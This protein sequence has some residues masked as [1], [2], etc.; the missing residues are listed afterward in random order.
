MNALDEEVVR[1]KNKLDAWVRELMQ[2]H[3]S[4]E[5]GCSFW[6]EQASKLNFDPK[7]DIKGFDDL[8]LFGFFEEMHLRKGP[9]EKWIVKGSK[10]RN[11]LF[12][13]ET[14]GT[15]GGSKVRASFDDLYQDYED[16]SK[17][18]TDNEFPRNSHWLLLGPSGPRRL[19]LSIEYL[20]QIRG[21]TCFSI[22]M[23]P[24]W[25]R[26]LIQGGHVQMINE[27]VDHCVDQA[28]GTLKS[29]QGIRCLFA[30]PRLL[31]ALCEK[32]SLRDLGIKGVMCGGT[33]MTPQFHRFVKEELLGPDV[34]FVPTY[35]NTLMGLAYSKPFE[36]DK[37]DYDIIYYPNQVRAVVEIIKNSESDEKVAY[38]ESGRVLLSTLT[39][40]FF[41]PKFLERDKGYREPPCKL[42][43]WDGVRN[44]SP[45]FEEHVG[46]QG[47][48]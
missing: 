41:M 38:G 5:T 24:R 43:P 16:F 44:V 15:T 39:K 23:D 33:Q 27:Y 8:S 12:V 40:E 21:G 31:E 2:W 35:G 14:G 4:P 3:F 10:K 19:R 32:V 48:Y 6:L 9:I 28:L 13:F 11:H 45:F 26:K 47:V 22:D 17:T 20:S 30:T 18:L 1:S 36:L 7:K 37:P 34:A 46:L 25:V 42:Y 29:Q